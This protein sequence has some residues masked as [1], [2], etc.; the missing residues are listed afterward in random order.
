MHVRVLICV[1]A[2]NEERRGAGRE[3][4]V[5][6]EAAGNR[7]ALRKVAVEDGVSADGHRLA[8]R[9]RSDELICVRHRVLEAVLQRK[10]LVAHDR[11]VR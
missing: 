5:R 3:A 11:L 9:R 7:A 8:C 2:R 10:D 6:K 1:R 4:A